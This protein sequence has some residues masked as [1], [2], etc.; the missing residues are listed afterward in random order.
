MPIENFV[1]RLLTSE[2]EP[3]LVLH[4]LLDAQQLLLRYL[5]QFSSPKDQNSTSHELDVTFW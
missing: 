2:K 3:M 4:S 1:H 5:D